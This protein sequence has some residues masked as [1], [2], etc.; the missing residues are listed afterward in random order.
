M[1]SS[2]EVQIAEGKEEEVYPRIPFI[3]TYTGRVVPFDHVNA[4]CIDIVDIAHSLSHQCRFTGHTC[5]FYS[6]A[7][8]SLLVS[9]KMPGGPADKLVGLLHDAAEAYT[10]DLS[11]PLKRW[12][13]LEDY[14]G[15]A[16]CDLQDHITAVVYSK[17]GVTNIPADVRM[18]DKA[19]CVFEAEGFLGL[20]NKELADYSFPLH[21]QGLWQP[22]EPVKFASMDSDRDFEEV[23]TAFLKRF[24]D[25]MD[26]LGRTH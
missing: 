3:V 7:Q 11:S 15:G 25:L 14:T 23:E 9:E 18:Y 8:H 13:E 21:L 1:I 22:W 10:S 19:A 6:V 17:F 4:A 5:H 24:E 20:S 12:M 2:K 26:S 16:Y